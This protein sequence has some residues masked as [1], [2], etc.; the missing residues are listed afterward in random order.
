MPILIIAL[1]LLMVFLFVMYLLDLKERIEKEVIYKDFYHCPEK[2]R[3]I[4]NQKVSFYRNLDEIKKREFE[5]KVQKFFKDYQIIGY[6]TSIDITDRILVAAGGVIPVFSFKSWKYS[7]L[8]IIYIVSD[9]FNDEIKTGKENCNI[10]GRVSN[11]YMYLSKPSLHLSFENPKDRYNS[12]IHEFAHLIDFED[13]EVDGFP[14][15]LLRKN[16]IGEWYKFIR[17]IALEKK[18]GMQNGNF[19]PEN[20]KGEISDYA[21]TGLGEFFAEMCVYYFEQPE[22]MKEKYPEGYHILH[23]AF[24]SKMKLEFTS[25]K[26]K[27]LKNNTKCPCKSGKI[28]ENCCQT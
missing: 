25:P 10:A 12:A 27:N 13:N 8:E 15:R 16:Y 26:M 19:A 23:Y 5:F 2:W 6:D 14:N 18:R 20:E 24:S 17:K 21:F 22:L 7:S 1:V 28:Y 4:L 9:N 11:K 3:N